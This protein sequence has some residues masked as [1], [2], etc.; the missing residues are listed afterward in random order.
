MFE[1]LFEYLDANF[2]FQKERPRLREDERSYGLKECSP[3]I[4]AY[5]KKIEIDEKRS[6]PL[7][8][9]NLSVFQYWDGISDEDISDIKVNLRHFTNVD[10]LHPAYEKLLRVTNGIS[11][12]NTKISIYGHNL[13][14][15][16][17]GPI[18]IYFNSSEPA[19]Y[20]LD[21]D[22]FNIGTYG[23][24]LAPIFI[25]K[26]GNI[27]VYSGKDF[28]A[29]DNG[30][31]QSKRAYAKYLKSYIKLI[32]YWDNI[33]DFITE[34][35]IR[36][37]GLFMSDPSALS[38]VAAL[39]NNVT[40]ELFNKLRG[41]KKIDVAQDKKSIA[42]DLNYARVNPFAD[43]TLITNIDRQKMIDDLKKKIEENK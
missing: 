41:E 4:A 9:E 26:D 37:I 39:P 36:Y 20:C 30:K 43:G 35:T 25:N 6:K 29:F 23:A 33:E 34:E 42:P 7:K 19:P 22:L 27:L 2:V 1:K 38:T 40:P 18:P 28:H 17:G 14:R 15:G 10:S 12:V 31:R 32:A 5:L 21:K 24:N 3:T 11:I 13:M 8:W 16:I